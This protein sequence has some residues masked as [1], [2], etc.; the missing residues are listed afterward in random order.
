MEA[1]GIAFGDIQD[2]SRGN[3]EPPSRRNIKHSLRGMDFHLYILRTV[4]H[5][6]LVGFPII[7]RVVLVVVET[8]TDVKTRRAVCGKCGNGCV[9]VGN[10]IETKCGLVHDEVSL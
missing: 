7:P 10:D 5:Y 4:C 1:N 2:E 9:C 8:R 6:G 3:K